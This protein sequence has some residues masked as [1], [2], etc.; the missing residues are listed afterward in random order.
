MVWRGVLT[1]PGTPVHALA[2]L[3]VGIKP[4]HR[5]AGLGRM[6]RIRAII[7]RGIAPP[8]EAPMVKLGLSSVTHGLAFG[9][10]RVPITRM[11][12]HVAIHLT[13]KDISGMGDVLG[14]P[15]ASGESILV[16]K[17]GQRT[18]LR[19]VD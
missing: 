18:N 15:L 12:A 17:W 8:D 6:R 5:Q 10:H 7:A 16:K 11:Q 9:Q 1:W 13:D 14:V 2:N 3:F 19:A 4:F